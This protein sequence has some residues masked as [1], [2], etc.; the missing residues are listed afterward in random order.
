LNIDEIYFHFYTQIF[1]EFFRDT[2][3]PGSKSVLIFLPDYDF[4]P[5]EVVVSWKW[6]TSYGI[7]GSFLR[8]MG[9]SRWGI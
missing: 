5:T 4:D 7:N 1:F 6:L 9:M 8:R 3:G 2:V